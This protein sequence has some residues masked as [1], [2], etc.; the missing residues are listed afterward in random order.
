MD[1]PAKIPAVQGFVD[2]QLFLHRLTQDQSEKFLVGTDVLH[3]HFVY[4]KTNLQ[5]HLTESTRNSESKEDKYRNESAFLTATIPHSNR[6]LKHLYH[7]LVLDVA[8]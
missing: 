8:N 7:F 3:P 2:A 5:M 1:V 4:V 6:F